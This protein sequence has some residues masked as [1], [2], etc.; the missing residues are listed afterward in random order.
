M[1][2]NITALEID[3]QAWFDN[4]EHMRNNTDE[5]KSVGGNNYNQMLRYCEDNDRLSYNN[6]CQENDVFAVPVQL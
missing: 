5:L 2:R 1:R 6:L 3:R 4:C